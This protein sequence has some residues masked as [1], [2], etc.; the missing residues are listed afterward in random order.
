MVAEAHELLRQE[1]ARMAAET[2]E[3]QSKDDKKAEGAGDQSKKA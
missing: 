3:L 1:E 2:R